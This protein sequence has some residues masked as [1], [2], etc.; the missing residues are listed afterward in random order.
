MK[1]DVGKDDFYRHFKHKSNL[2]PHVPYSHLWGL[3]PCGRGSLDLPRNCP[4][5]GPLGLYGLCLKHPDSFPSSLQPWPDGWWIEWC[6]LRLL[7]T[8]VNAPLTGQW[9]KLIIKRTHLLPAFSHFCSYLW[10]SVFMSVETMFI[11]Y[12]QLQLIARNE[13]VYCS[14]PA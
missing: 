5:G 10:E 11:S 2:I 12:N 3:S 8:G 4:R 13:S 9:R 14:C 1:T 6:S 7:G